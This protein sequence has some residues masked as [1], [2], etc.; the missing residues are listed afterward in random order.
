MFYWFIV[1]PFTLAIGSA[2]G[3]AGLV[4]ILVPVGLLLWGL[5]YVSEHSHIA[6]LILGTMTEL[7][8][9]SF[10]SYFALSLAWGCFGD[11]LLS[12][13]NR[14]E[15]TRSGWA[16]PW[17][18]ESPRVGMTPRVARLALKLAIVIGIIAVF[19]HGPTTWQDVGK[20]LDRHMSETDNEDNNPL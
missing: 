17:S 2:F 5:W 19:L 3:L 13:K 8:F 18:E 9:F 7:A 1:Y 12:G 6:S 10:I 16:K 15:L 4:V 14:H 20:F 11:R